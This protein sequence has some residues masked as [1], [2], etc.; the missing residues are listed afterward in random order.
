MISEAD[1]ISVH[2]ARGV[3]EP[4]L[5]TSGWGM[6]RHGGGGV[7]EHAVRRSAAADPDTAG[8]MMASTGT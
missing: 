8:A 7:L 1:V 5:Y 2:V 6:C 4:Q 3:L